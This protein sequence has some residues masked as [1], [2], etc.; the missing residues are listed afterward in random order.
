MLRFQSDLL[1]VGHSQCLSNQYPFIATSTRS[2]MVVVPFDL[3]DEDIYPPLVFMWPLGYHSAAR[4]QEWSLLLG[5]L[6]NHDSG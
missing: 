6:F 3:T 2:E 5:I 1:H 4:A